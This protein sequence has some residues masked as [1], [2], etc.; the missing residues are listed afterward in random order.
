MRAV[1]S[2]DFALPEFRCL[3]RLLLVIGRVNYFRITDL[4]K[5]FLYK[6]ILFTAP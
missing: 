6:N 2:S 5:Y 4:I 3:D 1:N